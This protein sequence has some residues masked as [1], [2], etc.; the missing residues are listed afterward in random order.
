MAE[1]AEE[2]VIGF[3]SARDVRFRLLWDEAPATCEAVSG[4]LPFAGDASHATHSGP[5]AVAFLDEE[6]PLPPE[7]VTAA[8]VPGELLYTYYAPG[9]RR[10]YPE[11]TSEIYWFYAPGGRPTVPG[12]FITAMASVFAVHEGVP[13][14]LAAFGEWS[15]SLHREGWKHIS[16]EAR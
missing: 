8:P 14:E 13:E 7:N 5:A 12:M 6:L 9:W 16:M 2:I 15:R 11:H 4:A 10:G 1:R 3:D